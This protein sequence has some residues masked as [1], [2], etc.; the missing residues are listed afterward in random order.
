MNPACGIIA[1]LVRCTARQKM[2]YCQPSE[3]FI[4]TVI[5]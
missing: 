3:I 5:G 4:P 1:R 2:F